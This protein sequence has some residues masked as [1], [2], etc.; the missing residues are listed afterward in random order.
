MP[1][2]NDKPELNVVGDRSTVPMAPPPG[3]AP[4][5][6]DAGTLSLHF[7][8]EAIS[9]GR[10][11]ILGALL[12]AGLAL[13]WVL[14]TQTPVYESDVVLQVEDRGRGGGSG[15]GFSNI[16]GALSGPGSSVA[17]E[18]EVMQSRQLLAGV[19][20]ALHLDVSA[21]PR[22]F[23]KIGQTI[24]SY[25]GGKTLGTP[26]F[27]FPKFAWG[28]ERI[29]ATRFDVPEELDNE[30]L[31]MLLIAGKPGEYDLLNGSRQVVARGEV[32]KPV[33]WTMPTPSGEGT[34]TI[35]I[36]ELRARPGTEFMVRKAS[37]V[38]AAKGLAGSF[39]FAEKGK[40]TGI[41]RVS[42]MAGDPAYAVA[43]LN[44]L[45]Q[46][47]LR[48][49]VE[50]RSA[51]AERTLQ[52]LDIQI[53]ILRQNLEA[54]ENALERYKATEGNAGVDLSLA[55]SS[56]LSRSVELERRLSEMELQRKEM[57]HRFMP[58]HPMV[59]ALAEKVEFLRAERDAVDRQISE[60]PEAE[61]ASVRL[62]RDV[63]VASGLYL[64]LLNRSQEL[65][66][67]KS[68][69]IGNVRILDP[70][71]MPEGPINPKRGEKVAFALAAGLLGGI[72]LSIGRKAL[73]QGIGDP[74]EA[75]RVTG[76]IVR[77]SIP[78]SDRLAAL[79]KERK[80]RKH[81][82]HPVLAATD[83]TDMAAE[84]LRSLRTSLQF[85]MMESPNKVIAIG[86]PR[87]G[88]GKSFVTVNLARVFADA[89]KRVLLLDAD[90]R[91]G[92]LHGYLGIH[93][94]P[95]LAEAIAGTV[96]LSEVLHKTDLA[97]IDFVPRGTSPT[98]P[99]ELLG[100]E[101]FRHMVENLAAE[102]D[103]VL[104]DLPPILAVTDAALVGRVAGVNLLV[105]RAGW[106][107]IRELHQAVKAY[108]ENGVRLAGLVFND[109]MPRKGG[110]GAYAYQYQYQ[111]HYQYAYKSKDKDEKDK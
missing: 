22:Y 14:G 63:A 21:S 102:Y 95:G 24:A 85:A 28:G 69:L 7:Y 44:A 59:Q 15:M 30:F 79:D 60:L 91:K 9:D 58:T 29:R 96:S 77:A 108:A 75:E 49:N 3:S 32:G 100:S 41:I 82:R 92:S 93:R 6:P 46:R 52:F 1:L 86:G 48:H 72:L 2:P 50:K 36:Q 65:K 17:T 20:D 97:G 83:P 51:E 53:P 61:S 38:Q 105:L 18:I 76:I 73:A 71:V 35:F 8:L 33:S 70:A 39:K 89:G 34:A 26:L 98:N 110:V 107:P 25:R 66:I 19:V 43:A 56:T 27:G 94:T 84:S 23:P 109:V 67:T 111:Y 37:R 78:H 16:E 104:I 31:G 54:A 11:I 99:S 81:A 74:T 55:T 10:W 64:T 103:I 88:V 101:R 47:Y 57:L 87:P 90:L 40:Y 62:K 12:V 106:H 68:G 4:H 5:G 13:A 45:A 42:M 80:K